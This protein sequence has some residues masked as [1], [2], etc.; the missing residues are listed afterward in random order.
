M[1]AQAS[2]TAKSWG[3]L[4][5]WAATVCLLLLSAAWSTSALAATPV[6][7][8]CNHGYRK[9]ITVSASAAVPNGY[10]VS[11]TFDHASLVFAGKAL[12][13]GNDV[14]VLYWTGAAWAEL[15]RLLD[16]GSAWNNGSTKIWFKTQASISSSSSDSNYYLYYGYSGAG[17]PP[18]NGANVF[19]FYDGFESGNF[20]A[21]D[22]GAGDYCP[23]GC[24]IAPNTST[25][26][27]GTYSA[28]ADVVGDGN[29]DW[30]RVT[31]TITGQTGLH[32]STYVYIPSGYSS[33][34]D[35]SVSI[36]TPGAGQK[37]SHPWPFE[38][39]TTPP[40]SG[41]PCMAIG[42]LT[43]AA[44]RSPSPALPWGLAHGIGSS[45]R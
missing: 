24:M 15:D 11:L 45:R 9:Q 12:A 21:W 4:G 33:T 35:I 38:G 25:V 19:L 28:K 3:R 22:G 27:T 31:K 36:S 42:S 39:A 23:T 7:W 10:T 20:S 18:A 40:T 30:A 32:A 6:W 14:R 1:I 37:R 8:N 41:S 13:S 34:E 16:P 5:R 29:H 2:L 43:T 44:R 26:H 17:S